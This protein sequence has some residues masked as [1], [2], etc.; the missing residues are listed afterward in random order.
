VSKEVRF[1]DVA[2][3]LDA[4]FAIEPINVEN[5]PDR[6]YLEEAAN[7]V[8]WR[9]KKAVRVTREAPNPVSRRVDDEILLDAVDCLIFSY[10]VDEIVATARGWRCWAP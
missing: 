4:R 5:V 9:D 8:L 10:L 7:V 3:V 6:C 1:L 2:E